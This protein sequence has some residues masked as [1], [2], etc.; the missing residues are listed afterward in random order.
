VLTISDL[1]GIVGTSQA[2]SI[3]G[4]KAYK[5]YLLH[6]K[7]YGYQPGDLNENLTW[8]SMSAAAINGAPLLTTQYVVAHGYS[9]RS[10]AGRYENSLDINLTLDGSAVTTDFG[11][12]MTIVVGRST[13]SG[14]LM[15]LEGS[16]VAEEVQSISSSF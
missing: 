13:L 12:T 11:V 15:K 4:M 5:S 3:T 14:L 10:G 9:Y 2:V 8:M 6:V 16:Y 7:I 1:S